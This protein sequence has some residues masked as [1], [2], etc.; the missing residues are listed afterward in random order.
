M[1][2]VEESVPPLG[3]GDRLTREEFLRLWEAH[4]EIKRAELIGGVVYMPSPVSVDHGDMEGTVGGLLFHYRVHTPGTANGNNTTSFLLDDIPQA[5][6]NLRIL[7]ECGGRSRIRNHYLHGVPEYFTE[8]C[9]SSASYD[10]HQKLDLYEAAGIPEYMA[11]LIFEREI[12]WHVLT[13]GRYQLLA[14]DVDGILRSKIFPG[15]W[16][17]G[18]AL[19]A[20]N[21]THVM[22]RLDEG[23]RSPEHQAFVQRLARARNEQSP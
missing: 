3:A 10:L 20:G 14:P 5:D 19:L 7:P 9:G 13:D 22:A 1:A 8:I 2:T 17:D 11:I 4:P 6:L 16:L 12:R 18:A 21:L 15:L 23:L